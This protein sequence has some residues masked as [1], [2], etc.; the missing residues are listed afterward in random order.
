MRIWNMSDDRWCHFCIIAWYK[1][2][3][4]NVL[5]KVTQTNDRRGRRDNQ[6]A[7]DASMEQLVSQIVR[8][9][10]YHRCEEDS[11]LSRRKW[12]DV[13]IKLVLRPHSANYSWMQT[14]S[15]NENISGV[16][17]LSKDNEE[18]K[19]WDKFCYYVTEKF[20]QGFF[21]LQLKT[22]KPGVWL[23]S[24]LTKISERKI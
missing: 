24:H 11:F 6:I 10:F 2:Q 22:W 21:I 4:G 20:S 18:R 17:Y 9:C 5:W 16:Y 23:V 12:V 19:L 13:E 3:R 1:I 7:Y 15:G 14:V 8:L